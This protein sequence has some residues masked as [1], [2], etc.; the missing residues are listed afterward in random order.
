MSLFTR[1]RSKLRRRVCSSGPAVS[2]DALGQLQLIVRRL[3]LGVAWGSRVFVR[4]WQER[5]V[6]GYLVNVAS[7][8]SVTPMPNMSACA[9]SKYAVEGLCEVLEMELAET[10]IR[11]SCVHPGVINTAIVKHD[12]RSDLPRE[13]V[14]RLQRQYREKSAHPSVV[15]NAIVDGGEERKTQHLYRTRHGHASDTE[16]TA[17]A[18]NVSSATDQGGA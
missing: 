4:L 12:E 10:P 14:E 9:A 5:G 13:Q 1:V 8:V 16:A 18:Q 6:A 3:V 2:G 17:A 7:A 15:A 11:G